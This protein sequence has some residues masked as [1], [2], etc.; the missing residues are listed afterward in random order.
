MQCSVVKMRIDLGRI[1]IAVAE[2]L[3]Q[4]ARIDT[5]FQHQRRGRVA[6]LVRGVARC[7]KSGELQLFFNHLLHAANAAEL[8]ENE[9]RALLSAPVVT[10]GAACC[11]TVTYW[12]CT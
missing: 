11:F 4:R 1:Q 8:S 9:I 3:L 12:L 5:V 7:V 10:D 2:D 6:Q